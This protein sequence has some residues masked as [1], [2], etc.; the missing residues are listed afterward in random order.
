MKT[1]NNYINE[2]LISKNT[3]INTDEPIFDDIFKHISI[4]SSEDIYNEY[5]YLNNIKDFI[6]EWI[7]K[8]NIKEVDGPYIYYSQKNNKEVEKLLKFI[9]TYYNN[10]YDD[11]KELNYDDVEPRLKN[12][13]KDFYERNKVVPYFNVKC[14]NFK[15]D[16]PVM[17]GTSQRL[18][19]SCV[20]NSHAV[21][22][23]FVK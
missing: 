17:F 13:F 10:I 22:I 15:C 1:L 6:K 4:Y 14:F 9:K 3:K 8:Y 11:Y 16:Y 18:S 23:Y 5:I 21:I 12:G 2:A 20:C 19:C 7:T